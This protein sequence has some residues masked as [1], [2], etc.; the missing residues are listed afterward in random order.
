MRFDLIELP[1]LDLDLG[2]WILVIDNP[3]ELISRLRA[4]V[5]QL[6]YDFEAAPVK[7]IEIPYS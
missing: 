1:D 7:Y 2:S 5:L 6:D 4:A 3:Y